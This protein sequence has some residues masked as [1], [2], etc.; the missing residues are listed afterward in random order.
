MC[1]FTP[2]DRYQGA[3]ED[4]YERVIRLLS[5][6]NISFIHFAHS[7]VYSFIHSQ[8]LGL[9]KQGDV[10][11]QLILRLVMLVSSSSG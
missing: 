9:Q 7:F 5:K 8:K 4:R 2:G 3:F 11:I 10:L 1:T 6:I